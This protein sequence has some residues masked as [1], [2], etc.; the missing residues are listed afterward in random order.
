M[1]SRWSWR[2]RRARSP[3][4]VKVGFTSRALPL[5]P[6]DSR[7]RAPLWYGKRPSD[8]DVGDVP[9]DRGGHRDGTRARDRSRRQRLLRRRGL[10]GLA[11]G[12]LALDQRLLEQAL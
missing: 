12:L 7:I 9:E 11:L 8:R 6:R 10:R 3:P 4:R 2:W 1:A 5:S